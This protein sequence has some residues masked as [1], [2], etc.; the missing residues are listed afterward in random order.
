MIFLVKSFKVLAFSIYISLTKSFAV[1]DRMILY[2]SVLLLW[3]FLFWIKVPLTLESNYNKTLRY[4]IKD[5]NLIKH[6]VQTLCYDSLRN[7]CV[8]S[9]SWLL[10]LF[11]T[12]MLEP[13]K[14]SY[15]FVY[16][17][18]IISF[19]SR[20]LKIH[21]LIQFLSTTDLEV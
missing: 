16:G 12:A 7:H 6:L 1:H 3:I 11:G 15:L 2:F 13:V 17:S 10:Y 5:P 9:L 21:I 19:P 8:N 20:V 14:F 4:I 18:I